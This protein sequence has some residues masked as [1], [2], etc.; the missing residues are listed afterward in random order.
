MN[1]KI[2]ADRFPV[3]R[4]FYYLFKI[5]LMIKA[6]NDRLIQLEEKINLISTELSVFR[7][8][9]ERV[10]LISANLTELNQK[11][12]VISGNLIGLHQKSD[13]LFGKM[14]NDFLI[15]ADNNTVFKKI[16]DFYF[17]IPSED[18]KL[19]IHL[20]FGDPE[21]GLD[22][23]LINNLKKGSTFVDIGAHIGMVTLRAALLLGLEGKVYSFEPT[24]RIYKLLNSNIGINGFDGIVESFQV[25]VSDKKGIA[26]FNLC[27]IYGLNTLFP[28]E[29]EGTLIE[30]ETDSLDN[31]LKYV[32]HI[33]M[34]KID[35]EGA[36]PLILKGMEEIIIKNPEVVIIMEFGIGHFQRNGMDPV[37][38]LKDIRND[39]FKI[40][41]I[42][43]PTGEVLEI[44][45][46]DLLKTYSE[47]II[48]SKG[49]RFYV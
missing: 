33:D 19:L 9:I 17:G 38:F 7:T 3:I 27:D 37:S 41:L 20:I 11:T 48:L 10:D 28:Y 16:R 21:P 31:I 14:D 47:N 5:P 40:Y 2:F 29:N 15:Y 23:F 32:N 30:V 8:F 22:R 24:P 42:K 13:N 39:G 6:N 34:I 46:E 49:N 18:H 36:E 44:S 43:E 45:D 4:W 25:A 1:K 26:K 12:D 35:A